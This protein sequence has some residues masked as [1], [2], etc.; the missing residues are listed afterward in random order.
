M[1][2]RDVCHVGQEACKGRA[3][4][5]TTERQSIKHGKTLQLEEDYRILQV[6]RMSKK[7]NML[8]MLPIVAPNKYPES[9]GMLC[10]GNAL[11]GRI[12]VSQV[13]LR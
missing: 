1:Q 13:T 9:K 7:K 4:K 5:N 11:I 12:E 6:Q 2:S 8:N 10:Q 3:K